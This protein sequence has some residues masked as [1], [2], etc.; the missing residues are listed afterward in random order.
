M[1]VVGPSGWNPSVVVYSLERET[2][3]PNGCLLTSIPV[4]CFWFLA[5][6]GTGTSFQACFYSPGFSTRDS[7]NWICGNISVIPNSTLKL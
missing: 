5:G 6:E 2:L 1:E 4:T 7:L 3:V